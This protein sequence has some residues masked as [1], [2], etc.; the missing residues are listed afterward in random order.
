MEAVAPHALLV[1]RVGQGV[2]VGHLGMAAMEGG[3]EAGDLGNPGRRSRI[4]RMGARLVQRR[5]RV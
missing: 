3:V 2:A 1:Q 4:T 5:Q